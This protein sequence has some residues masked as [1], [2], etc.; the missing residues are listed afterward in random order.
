MVETPEDPLQRMDSVMRKGIDLQ[1]KTPSDGRWPAGAVGRPAAVRMSVS[2][3]GMAFVWLGLWLPL[4]WPVALAAE[5]ADADRADRITQVSLINALMLGEY[6]GFV[7]LKDL[8]GS[9]D[10]GLGTLDRLD[11][12]LIVLDGAAYQA[13]SSG[14]VVA[15]PPTA[16]TPF[17]TITPFEADGTIP[18]PKLASLEDLDQFLDERLPE[19]NNFVAIRIEAGVAS[20]TLRSVP[21]Q[22]RPF[23]PLQV[24][25]RSQP[26]W[27]HRG[28]RG[29]FVGIR[30][31]QWAR[32]IT[33]P[34]YH[35]HFLSA[36][37]RIGGHVLECQ[38]QEGT[39]RFDV[40]G[41][42]T[43]KL[44][45]SAAFNDKDLSGDLREQVKQV[46]SPRGEFE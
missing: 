19:R 46:E 11:G 16:T 38:I 14:E 5:Q 45:R 3:S 18:C 43:V 13:R 31:P 8:L 6:D 26:I 22:E 20:I 9:G 33:V 30:S 42:W 7:S 25:A 4:A 10:F 37:R 32:D 24:I 40:C 27:T 29:S 1:R 34:G 41:D 36:D 35:W 28:I 17:A 2:L 12:E 44:D 23:K 21:A 15:V 39:I